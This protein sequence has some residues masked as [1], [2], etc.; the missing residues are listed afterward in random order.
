MAKIT[1]KM[2]L[3]LGVL[4]VLIVSV[5]GCT[6]N[7][8]N[9]ATSSNTPGTNTPMAVTYANNYLTHLKSTLE[10]NN[11]IP[12]SNVVQNGSD[13]AQLT[14]TLKNT[15]PNSIWANGTATTMAFNIKQ[16]PSVD[17]ATAFYNSQSFGYTIMTNDSLKGT[18]VPQ[19]VVY[20]Q[21]MGHNATLIHGATK[22]GSISFLQVTGST[23]VQQ[24]EFVVWGD[25]SG[26]PV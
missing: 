14:F 9:N 8:A 15:T 21:T 26:M 25:I 19:G 23:I 2:V 4:A 7:V 18:G 12:S 10:P 11:T 20:A 16:F 24:D 3:M 6:S 22:I 17:A 5:A 1:L 13:A